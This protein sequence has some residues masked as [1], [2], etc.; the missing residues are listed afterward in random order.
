M[1]LRP[2]QPI[3]PQ[4]LPEVQMPQENWFK[5]AIKNP[6]VQGALFLAFCTTNFQPKPRTP[7]AITW[8]IVTQTEGAIANSIPDT[9]KNEAKRK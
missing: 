6:Y 9:S 7:A 2:R 4:Q 8:H 5:I 1:R 3:Q